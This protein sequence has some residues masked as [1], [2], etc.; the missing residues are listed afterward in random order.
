MT[1]TTSM[2]QPAAPD[3][4]PGA[5]FGGIMSSAIG[6]VSAKVDD[7]S[8]KLEEVAAGAPGSATGV[9]DD[10]ADDVA[11]GGGAKRQAGVR[12]VQAAMEG[13]NP[14]WAAIKGA[15]TGGSTLVRAAVVAAG[16]ALLLLLVLSPVLLLAFLLSALIVAAVTKARSARK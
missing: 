3:S 7:W 8:S 15:W 1:A 13:K 10:V 6:V 14:V 9:A 12:G 5:A 16:A 4:S 11:A 2:P